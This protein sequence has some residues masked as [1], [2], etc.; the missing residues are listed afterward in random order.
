MRHNITIRGHAYR[1]RPVADTD[2]ELIVSLRS[3]AVLSR[4]LHTTSPRVEDQLAWLQRYY[5]RNGDY[6]FVI[7]R[8][9]DSRA[10]GLIAI[11]D[12]DTVSK[13]AEWGRWILRPDS[14]AAVESCWLI[15]GVGFEQLGMTEIFCRTVADNKKVV[16]FHDSCGLKNRRTLSNHVQIGGQTFD[17]VEHRLDKDSWP[18]IATNLERISSLAARRSARD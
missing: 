4:F 7:E 18:I 12:L 10:E 17:S 11:Y 5:E 15:Y 1:L 13:T 3:D 9:K 16:S 6:Y 8:Q 2:A 14:N